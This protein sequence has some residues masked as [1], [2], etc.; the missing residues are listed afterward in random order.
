MSTDTSD[1]AVLTAIKT[2]NADY[3]DL[4]TV[5]AFRALKEAR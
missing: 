5:P 1:A 3:P 4:I 2:L